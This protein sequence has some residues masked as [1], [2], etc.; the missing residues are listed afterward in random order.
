MISI[1]SVTYVMF[2]LV[3]LIVLAKPKKA[4]QDWMFITF[5]GALAIGLFAPFTAAYPV[6]FHFFDS[7]IVIAAP[8]LWFYVKAVL[9]H[10]LSSR[11]SWHLAIVLPVIFVGYSYP[12]AALALALGKTIYV[13]GY[14]AIAMRVYFNGTVSVPPSVRTYWFYLLFGGMVLLCISGALSVLQAYLSPATGW[15]VSETVTIPIT[16]LLLLALIFAGV[17]FH[18]PFQYYADEGQYRLRTPP[19]SGHERALLKSVYEAFEASMN[20]EKFFL[21][22]SYSLGDAAKILGLNPQVLSQAINEHSSGGFSEWMAQARTKE[23]L[24]ILKD[25]KYADQRLLDIGLM[26]GF[27]SK[28]TFNRIVKE[29][30]GLSPRQLRL[31]VEQESTK[32]LQK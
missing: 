28:A 14:L 29:Q 5:L 19:I 13:F 2:A 23:F 22:S 4:D 16:M 24:G 30:T 11:L 18:S 1:L 6:V 7:V 26:A 12:E 8:L 25:E 20:A 3:F 10:P 27:G 21:E 32:S 9:G 15:L 31:K 17:R